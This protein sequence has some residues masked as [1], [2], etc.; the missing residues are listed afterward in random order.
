MKTIRMMLMV[1]F[2]FTA[3]MALAAKNQKYELKYLSEVTHGRV[4][5][6]I[7]VEA[8]DQNEALVKAGQQCVRDLLDRKIAR[9]DI[10]DMC[11]NPRL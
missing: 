3:V 1:S 8:Q 4:I 5:H 2:T 10:V 6:T 11:N 9:E 7:P